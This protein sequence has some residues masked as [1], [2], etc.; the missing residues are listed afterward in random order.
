MWGEEMTRDYL[1]R[2]GFGSVETKQIESDLNNH[3]YVIRP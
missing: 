3:W 1:S 2:A